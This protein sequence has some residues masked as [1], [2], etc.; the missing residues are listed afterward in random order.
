MK[1]LPLS[2]ALLLACLVAALHNVT[3]DDPDTSIKYFPL[4]RWDQDQLQRSPLDIGGF[5]TVSV[6]PSATATLTFTGTHIFSIISTL[7]LTSTHQELPSTTCL[8][9]GRFKSVCLSAWTMDLATGS[10]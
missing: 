2:L 3:I 7:T 1:L 8:Q 6:D 4:P 9:S 5:H 10:I